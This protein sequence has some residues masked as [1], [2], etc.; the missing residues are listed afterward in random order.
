MEVLYS[1]SFCDVLTF[2]IIFDSLFLFGCMVAVVIINF[3]TDRKKK[4]EGV[5]NEKI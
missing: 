1:L 3:F 5:K 2:W 4:R